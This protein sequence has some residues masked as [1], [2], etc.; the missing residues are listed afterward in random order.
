VSTLRKE[1]GSCTELPDEMERMATYFRNLFTRDPTV[2]D[3]LVINLFEEVVSDHMN[4]DLCKPFSNQEI[5]DA[6]FQ[7][8]SLKA[9]GLDGFPARFFSEELAVLKA[10]VVRAMKIFFEAEGQMLDDVNKS[11]VLIAKINQ[12]E[13]LKES[14]IMWW[15]NV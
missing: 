9:L 15:L 5:C 2:D 4:D 1:D 12:P 8:G 11:I 13:E 7:I 6:L 14:F 10:D 3:A